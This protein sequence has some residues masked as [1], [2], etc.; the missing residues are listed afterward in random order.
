M[1]IHSGKFVML[2]I[3]CILF[4]SLEPLKPY[5]NAIITCNTERQRKA[6]EHYA[7]RLGITLEDIPDEHFD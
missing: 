3:S 1:N 4:D 2:A 7:H 5:R 6:I